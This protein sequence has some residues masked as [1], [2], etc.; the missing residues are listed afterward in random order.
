[1]M[2]RSGKGIDIYVTDM[3]VVVAVIVVVVKIVGYSYNHS[4]QSLIWL[5]RSIAR[6][7]WRL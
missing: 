1:M 2:Y 3:S 6:C 5:L 7:G 4:I